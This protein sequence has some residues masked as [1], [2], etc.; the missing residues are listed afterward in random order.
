MCYQF[1]MHTVNL[2]SLVSLWYI[3][4]ADKSPI[5]FYEIPGSKMCASSQTRGKFDRICPKQLT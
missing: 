3:F 2:K 4:V 5:F 1:F